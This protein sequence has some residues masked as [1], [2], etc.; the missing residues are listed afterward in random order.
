MLLTSVMS[1]PNSFIDSPSPAT[2]SSPKAFEV[3]RT[4]AEASWSVGSSLSPRHCVEVSHER[5]RPRPR[6]SQRLG[7]RIWITLSAAPVLP[8]PATM[9]LV[10]CVPLLPSRETSRSNRGPGCYD[11]SSGA[12]HLL[13][14]LVAKPQNER[15]FFVRHQSIPMLC[16]LVE[17]PQLR[18]VGHGL[19]A[20]LGAVCGRCRTWPCAQ[21]RGCPREKHTRSDVGIGLRS[22]T[23]ADDL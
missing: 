2:S 3:L 18:M 6:T 7:S 23:D 21:P 17:R 1:R 16:P 11:A 5:T 9:V 19:L 22:D 12:F 15:Q 8:V 20:R 10:A 4:A 14:R 13:R